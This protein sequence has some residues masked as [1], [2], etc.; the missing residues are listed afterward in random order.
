MV[1]GMKEL[2][3]SSFPLT[4][5]I[6]CNLWKVYHFG[7]PIY[8]GIQN[9][10]F[11]ILPSVTRWLLISLSPFFDLGRGRSLWLRNALSGDF[12]I[13]TSFP[14]EIFLPTFMLLPWP[15]FE[16]VNYNLHI[17]MCYD[18]KSTF[19]NKMIQFTSPPIS[20]GRGRDP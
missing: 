6:K 17:S 15:N 1:F 8:S 19:G 13:S 4:W 14:A 18:F 7:L 3:L 10:F 11:K 12:M 2:C 20:L 5:A 9:I 16:K